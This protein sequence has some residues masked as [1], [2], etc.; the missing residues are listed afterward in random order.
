MLRLAGA[1]LQRLLAPGRSVFTDVL[2]SGGIRANRTIAR[3]A[4]MF[5]LPKGRD[6]WQ[7]DIQVHGAG[8]GLLYL[9]LAAGGHRVQKCEEGRRTGNG[10]ATDIYC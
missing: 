3:K 6:G 7:R 10:V 2:A 4:I 8:T 9:E 5:A 1:A